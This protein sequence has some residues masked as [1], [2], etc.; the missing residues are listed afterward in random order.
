MLHSLGEKIKPQYGHMVGYMARKL[1]HLGLE[2]LPPT[3]QSSSFD[4]L[5]K[6]QVDLL[7]DRIDSCSHICQKPTVS[8]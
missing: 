7:N 6:L 4:I 3:S 5:L 8:E 2:S 1:W